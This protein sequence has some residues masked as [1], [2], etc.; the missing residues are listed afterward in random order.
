MESSGLK[1]GFV[2]VAGR[3]N[4]GKS[5]L[6]N[7]LCGAKVAIVSDKPQTTRR[8]ILGVANGAG[9]QLVLADLPGF[10]RPLDALTEHMQRTV[11]AAFED[12]EA[13][14]FVL[15]ARERIGAGDRFIARRV[16][17]VGVPVV[18]ALNK[19]DRLKGGHIATQM[20]TASRLG[21]FHALHPVSAKTGDGVAALRDELVALLPDGPAYFPQEQRSDLSVE[22]Q[23]AELVREQ[24]LRLTKDEVPHAITVEVQEIEEKLVQADVLVETGSQK[25]IVVGKGG[26]MVREIGRRARPEIEQLLGHPVYLELRVK[27]K[28]RW[29]R[30][31]T[32][33]QRLGI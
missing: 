14:L 16:F 3:P 5:T 32:L 17:D 21:E 18:I 31:E 10:Q 2:A 7:A 6:V 13:I 12:I 15:S 11:D 27:V 23:I 30:D 22:A 4:V 1:S 24:A 28:P 29:R 25:Q 20:D 9:Y 33:L 19:V 26:A 8:R